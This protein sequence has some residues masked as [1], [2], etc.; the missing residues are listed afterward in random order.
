MTIK[1][2]TSEL[3]EL[4]LKQVGSYDF[5][6]YK[7]ELIMN[8][9]DAEGGVCGGI[10]MRNVLAYKVCDIGSLNKDAEG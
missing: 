6:Y 8:I 2:I 4:E 9:H 1:I 10:V 3:R 5:D 7:N